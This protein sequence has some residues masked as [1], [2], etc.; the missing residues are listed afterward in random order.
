MKIAFILFDGITWLDLIGV[1]DPISRLKTMHYLP[2]LTWDFCS[3]KK[4]VSDNLGLKMYAT[5]INK[6]LEN[7]DVIVVPGGL[8]TRS[9]V[10]DELF[11][12]WLKTASSV[13]YKVSVCTGSLLLG[14]AGFL[15]DKTATTH[16]NTYE[17]LKPFCKKVSRERIIMDGKIVTAG[18][19]ASA[20]DLGL[21]LCEKWAGKEAMLQIKKSMD[22]HG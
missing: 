10:E 1:Y 4:E 13:P 14:A 3:C 2:D 18:A 12:N 8:G 20:L 5:K 21:F 19:V 11:I 16:F 9:L 6:N 22:Y 15:K 17:L 7:Y